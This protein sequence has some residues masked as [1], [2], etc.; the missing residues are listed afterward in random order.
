[1][2]GCVLVDKKHMQGLQAIGGTWSK[3]GSN[4]L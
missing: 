2:V 3:T 1:M 4:S